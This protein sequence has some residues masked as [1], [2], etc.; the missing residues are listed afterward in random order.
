MESRSLSFLP[1][2][3]SLHWQ[4]SEEGPMEKVGRKTGKLT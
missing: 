4:A 2:I 3:S 1:G